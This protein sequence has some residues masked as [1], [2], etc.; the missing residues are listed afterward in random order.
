[1]SGRGGLEALIDAL[2]K[3]REFIDSELSILIHI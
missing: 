3:G 2:Y 1:M